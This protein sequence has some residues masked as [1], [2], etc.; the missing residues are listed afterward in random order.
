MAL[1]NKITVLRRTVLLLI[2]VSIVT[3]AVLIS[4]TMQIRETIRANGLSQMNTILSH[5][6]ENID[7]YVKCKYIAINNLIHLFNFTSNDSQL[8]TEEFWERPS[9]SL[10]NTLSVFADENEFYDMFVINSSGN[11][12]YTVKKE[13]DNGTNLL[14]GPYADSEL[15]R[16]FRDAMKDHETYISDYKYYSPSHD[17]AAFMAKP[18]IRNGKIIGVLAA[19]I[20]N[21]SI[22]KILNDYSELGNSGKVFAVVMNG[23]KLMSMAPIRHTPIGSYDFL[24]ADR[25]KMLNNAF[26]KTFGQQYIKNATGRDVAIAWGYEP[27]LHWKIAV[28]INESELLD[29]W[30]KQTVS[31]GVLFVMGVVIVIMLVVAGFRSLFRPIQELTYNAVKMSNGDYRVQFKTEKYDL[32]WQILMDAFNRMSSDIYDKLMQLRDQN[33]LLINQKSEIEKLNQ[34]LEAKIVQKSKKLQEYINIVDQHVITSQTDA[35][36]LIIYASV[37]FCEISGYTKEEL[38]GKNHRIIRHP[39]MPDSL[40]KEMWETIT[41]GKIWRGEIKNLKSDG[42]YY[43]VDTMISPN[44]EDGKIVGYTAVRHDIT[45][46]KIVEDLAITDGLTG[47]FNRRHYAQVIQEEMN[48]VNRHSYSIALMMLD[49][50]N[51]KLY[52]DTYGH[53]AGDTILIKISEILR[54]YTL[55]SGEYAFRL[56]GEEFGILLSNMSRDEYYAL[57]NRICSAVENL[58]LPHAQNTAGEYV[59]VSIGIAVYESQSAMSCDDIYKEAD[60]QL[61]LAKE[62][63]RNRVMIGE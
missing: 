61:Y 13:S 57:A 52:N 10:R 38:I 20:D 62:N 16:V 31:L 11:I 12:V 15:S 50:D 22:Q 40:F 6:M 4:A 35:N 29:E 60:K 9:L 34:T 36:G 7:T 63:G 51:F 56:G 19:Q 47:L 24:D 3:F 8:F 17:Y 42:G 26:T 14:N 37:A 2:A 59:T 21:K 32:E 1:K 54:S 49:V 45:Y 18:I 58:H 48:R 43:W 25:T 30:Y 46:Q 23:N 28:S 5:K 33:T 39:D 55:R 27:Q 44:I 53:A 41:A